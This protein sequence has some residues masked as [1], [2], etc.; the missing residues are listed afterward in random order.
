MASKTTNE[1]IARLRDRHA[2]QKT[3]L[4]R[5]HGAQERALAAVTAGEAAVAALLSERESVVARL[6]AAILVAR[7]ECD[8]AVA[9]LVRLSSVESAAELVGPSV[10]EVRRAAQR[11]PKE[12]VDAE[13][14]RLLTGESARR[15]RRRAVAP[16]PMSDEGGQWRSSSGGNAPD[17]QGDQSG[18]G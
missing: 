13:V 10:A 9:V 4:Q 8:A 5:R 6:D 18:A 1:A 11:V 3:E 2:A 12:L 7:D 17:E 14:E 15:G 16:E